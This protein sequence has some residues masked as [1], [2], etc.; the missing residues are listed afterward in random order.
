[1]AEQV[2]VER[3]HR[4]G[5][6]EGAWQVAG[7]LAAVGPAPVPEVAVQTLGHFAV[8]LDGVPVPSAAWQSRK[9]RELVRVLAGQFGRPYA[10][11]PL[12]AVLWPGV[13]AEVAS[14]RLSVLVSTVRAVLDPGRDH[15]ADRYLRTD[16]GTVRL[17]PVH[18]ALDT[19]RFHEAARAAVAADGTGPVEGRD[20]AAELEILGRLEVVVAMYTG[21]FCDDGEVTGDWVERPRAVLAELHREAVQRLARRCLRLGRPEAAVGWYLRLTADDGYDESAHL[22]LIG[23][24]SAVGRHGEAAR[25]Y[26]E[27]LDR[28]REI[29][30]EPAAFPASPS[31][32]A[33]T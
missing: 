3:L 18:V 30:V 10:R 20:R 24:L 4:L 26:R 2:A 19:A 6:R 7:P 31:S 5:V 22:G 12:A 25:R 17:D 33:G 27:Y 23:A 28:M 8:R 11:E 13:P 15:P 1:M 29:E 16:P 14:R 21:D 32:R 9:A